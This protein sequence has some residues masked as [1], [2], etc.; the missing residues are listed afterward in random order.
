MSF[1]QCNVCSRTPQIYD[2]EEISLAQRG[3]HQFSAG[4][5]HQFGAGGFG[6]R[7]GFELHSIK[8][9][10]NMVVKHG[11]KIKDFDKNRD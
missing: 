3:P 5:S 7:R 2:E 6:T 10:N 1:S 11:K 4:G 8:N 9:R